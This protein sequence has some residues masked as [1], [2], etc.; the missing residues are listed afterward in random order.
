M[1]RE[2][3]RFLRVVAPLILISALIAAFTPVAFAAARQS[4]SVTLVG[5]KSH[6]LVLGDSLAYGYQPNLDWD[7]GYANDFYNNLKSHGESHEANMACP[8]ETTATMINGG[9]EFSVIRKYLY[10]GPQL[11]AAV[12]YLR[13]NAGQVSPVTLD[14]GANDLLPDL[15][16]SNCTVSATWANDLAAM[17]TNLKNVILPELQAALTVNGQITGDLLLMNYYDPYQN[18]CPN[19][20]AYIQQINT[21]LAADAQG[22]A[23]V[24]DVFD[25]FGG[26]TTPDPNTCNYTWICSVFK[27]IHARDAG[28]Q[29]IAN[30]FEQAAGY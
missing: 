27:D 21:H 4:Q 9:C 3:S 20:V 10:T 22:F 18:Q 5:P 2:V 6:Y 7:N 23:T 26:A 30:A 1:R 15:N 29:V 24:A 11:N 16:T 28:Y 25:A 19:T 14:I 17:D 8:G 13:A 12:K